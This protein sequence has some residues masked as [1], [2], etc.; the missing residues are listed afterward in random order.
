MAIPTLGLPVSKLVRVDVFMSPQAA[1]TRSF[2]SLLICGDSD[3]IDV[4]ERIRQ[5]DTVEAVGLDFGA[6][7][8]EYKAAVLYYSQRPRPADLYIGRWA[9]ERDGNE[10]FGDFV[11]RVGVV[12]PV[13]DS[14]RDFYA[15]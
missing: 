8:P 15:A 7:S 6:E 2:G 11:I 1:A 4:T 5:Y 14:A 3:V 12:A 9:T 13:I 10:C